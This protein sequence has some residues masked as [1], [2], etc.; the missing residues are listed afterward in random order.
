LDAIIDSIQPNL[1]KS[2]GL[3]YDETEEASLQADG[4]AV[5]EINISTCRRALEIALA[6]LRE[7]KALLAMSFEI[8]AAHNAMN[9]F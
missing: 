2:Q 8:S 9:L 7:D 6:G 5:A 1:R 3:F 4:P